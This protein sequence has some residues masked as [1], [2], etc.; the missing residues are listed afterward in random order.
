MSSPR[1][2]KGRSAGFGIS[3]SRSFSASSG[4]I[5]GI[6]FL[7]DTGP[8]ESKKSSLPSGIP[9]GMDILR[10][11]LGKLRAPSTDVVALGILSLPCRCRVH[12]EIP[13]VQAALPGVLP[14]HGVDGLV[15]VHQGV[16]EP[17]LACE[18][19]PREATSAMRLE[20]YVVQPQTWRPRCLVLSLR[21]SSDLWSNGLERCHGHG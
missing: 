20:S 9:R 7:R 21:N 8:F 11:Q 14:H 6:V 12:G 16:V 1:A 3:Q 13:L 19:G 5:H 17:L 10:R 4:L 18:G 2:L 15:G